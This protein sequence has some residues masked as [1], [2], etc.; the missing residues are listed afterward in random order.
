MVMGTAS[1]VGKTVLTAGLLR[2]LS[3]EGLEAAPFKAVNISLNSTATPD[4]AEIAWSQAMQAEAARVVPTAAMN[5]VLIKPMAEGRSQIVLDGRVLGDV[6]AASYREVGFSWRDRLWA[7]IARSVEDLSSQYPRLVIEGS[8]SPAEMNLQDADLANMRTAR[9]A[10]ARVLLVADIERGGVFAAI[11]GTLA[12]L[13]PADRARIGG[14]VINRFRGDPRF[15]DDGREWLEAHTGLPVLGVI[16]HLEGL[17]LVEEDAL[18]LHH[19]RYRP[20][21]ADAAVLSVA[22]VRL[23]HLANFS[24]LDPLFSDPRL[25]VEWCE[26]LPSATP[27]VIVLPGTKNTL[28]DLEWLH[29]RGWAGYI[30]GA[31]LKGTAVFGICGGYQM[32]GERVSDPDHVESSRDAVAGLGLSRHV[33]VLTREKSVRRV[34]GTAAPPLPPH[35]IEGYEIHM[36]ATRHLAPRKPLVIL[37]D[38]PDGFRSDDGRLLGTYVHGLLDSDAFREAWLADVADARGRHWPRA[39]HASPRKRRER[40]Y[41]LL[42]AHLRR[43]LDRD[44][45]FTLLES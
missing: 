4:G 19:P 39:S 6:T 8:G 11:V 31:F 30:T 29:A 3:D 24:D 9:L 26:E 40:S 13:E 44:R 7:S 17:D 2:L 42:A 23:P 5:P 27:D 43:H 12:L 45:L 21:T 34:A 18:G 41:D 33:T 10:Q 36:G 32:L 14:L 25:R 16:P 20:S 35:A 37:N 22:A 15:F 1:H 28:G 38:G